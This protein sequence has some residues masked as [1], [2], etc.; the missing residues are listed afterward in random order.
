VQDFFHPPHH[1]DLPGECMEK[2]SWLALGYADK[3]LFS[4]QSKPGKP[5]FSV[6]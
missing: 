3:D 6:K 1:Y 2:S 5:G 4:T